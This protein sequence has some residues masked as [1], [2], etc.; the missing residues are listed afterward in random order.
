MIKKA[1]KPEVGAGD[2]KNVIPNI[3]IQKLQVPKFD[4]SPTS[5]F[6]WKLTFERYMKQFD[7]ETKYDYLYSYTEGISHEYVMNKSNYKD[8]IAILD[9][10][11]GNKH[12]ILKSLL[13]EIRYLPVVKRG[14][15]KTFENLAF[16]VNNFRDRLIE[17]SLGNEVE[18]SYILQELESKLCSED[19]YK[20]FGSLK[21]VNHRKVDT[22]VNWLENQT[23]IRRLTLLATAGSSENHI[24]RRNTNNN[25][26]VTS[27]RYR[28][29][30]ETRL[31]SNPIGGN[32]EHVTARCICKNNHDGLGNCSLFPLIPFNEK[33][34]VVK[35]EGVCFICLIPGHQRTECTAQKCG[36]CAGPHHNL[37]HN[38]RRIPRDNETLIPNGNNYNAN[39]NFLE[40]CEVKSLN[41]ELEGNKMPGRSFLPIVSIKIRNNTYELSGSALLDSGSEINILSTKCCNQL[42]LK[43]EP[44]MINI[45]GAGGI[46]IRKNTKKVT[47]TIV[48]DS[49]TQTEIE[50]IVLDDACGKGIP[51]GTEILERFN[52]YDTTK[53]NPWCNKKREIDIL[54]GMSSPYKRRKEWLNVD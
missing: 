53:M 23:H 44:V 17:M 19:L 54:I 43:G 27:E 3:R 13:D 36:I 5:Y 41:N 52:E 33:W 9:E 18:N 25:T 8:A 49:G 40:T 32:T 11:F 22:L 4:N 28:K 10:K 7:D 1:L 48:E 20:W 47:L 35:S 42:K 37:L 46:V 34:N 51:M 29:W 38:P 14:D 6:K 45:I 2:T 50:C 31:L 21:D 16:K 39:L 24:Y 12:I 26:G 15:Y 30:G